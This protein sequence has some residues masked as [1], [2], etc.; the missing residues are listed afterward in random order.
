MALILRGNGTVE[1]MTS[2][3]DLPSS[4]LKSFG[5]E[6]FTNDTGTNMLRP[7]F[8]A[9]ATSATY[10]HTFQGGDGGSYANVTSRSTFPPW[11]GVTGGNT[12]GFTTSSTPGSAWYDI[13]MTGYYS[14][15]W[16]NL[17]NATP[18]THVDTCLHITDSATNT[19]RSYV[20]WQTQYE[21]TSAT[22]YGICG[23]SRS[24]DNTN[25]GGIGALTIH[26]KFY[27][28]QRIRPMITSPS[29]WSVDIYGDAHSYWHGIFLGK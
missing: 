16:T 23:F 5:G 20:P 29:S 6:T 13:P 24:W 15:S 21:G 27:E 8:M 14:F 22:E 11:T 1:G 28:G 10:N 25:A 4:N 3:P 2:A 12:T 18:A 19:Y 26:A 7:Q 9:K 17:V